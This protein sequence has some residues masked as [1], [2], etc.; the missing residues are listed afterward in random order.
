M[1]LIFEKSA[2]DC[3]KG[4]SYLPECDVPEVKAE[5]VFPKGM[6]RD[7]L[8]LPELAEVEVVRHYVA[9]ARRNMGVDVGFYPLGSCT[10]KYNP[11]I[12]E[13]LA[14]L[15]A[16][17]G[18]HPLAPEAEAQGAMRLIYEMEDYLCRIAGMDAFTF[19]PAAGAHGEMTGMMLMRR[20]FEERG[21]K[22]TKM[23]V[24][25]SSHGTNP[26]SGA[27][28]GFKVVEVKSDGRGNVDLDD[29]KSKLGDDTAGIMMTNP[30]TLGLFEEKVLEIAKLVHGAGGLLYYDGANL[31]ALLGQCRPG[32]MGFD[33]VHL[34]LHKTFATPHGGG[35]PGSGPVGV[36][37]R[38]ADYLPVPRLVRQGG[39][40]RWQDKAEKS[41]GRITSFYGN[42]AVVL[43]A[44][45]YIRAL[46]A[47]GLK[48]VS[49]DA[50]LNA[51]YILEL[52]KEKYPPAY[53]RKP[54]HEFVVSASRQK[55]K[56]G[57]ALDVAKRLI[58]Y[59]IHPPTIY[60]PLIVPEAMMVEPTET[61][62][63]ETLE[64][65]AEAMLKIDGEISA[66]PDKVRE[67]PTTTPVSRLD[68][69]KAA[70]QPDINYK[71]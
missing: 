64:T 44:Y 43:K 49:E 66:N 42:F 21:E 71:A 32:D 36:C 31:N 14:S 26:A 17:A 67:A 37:K 9:L 13:R 34:N 24:P 51:N 52:I 62:G 33:I 58:D 53:D 3:C 50:V 22:R 45:F 69:V 46:G 47:E 12:N 70:R 27:L 60:F 25:D 5:Q 40:Y 23:L 35:G 18:L 59:G 56:G 63:K 15:P 20:Y 11:K 41:I 30:N 6:L 48:R 39:E 28:C 2:K 54:M 10:M 8:D 38:L 65:F 4:G 1:E 55:K 57:S 29:L 61:E 16:F 68:E 19:Q 7:T